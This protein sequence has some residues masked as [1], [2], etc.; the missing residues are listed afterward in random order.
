MVN[1]EL[2][3]L[4][5][6]GS[7]ITVI[8]QKLYND[9]YE[10]FKKSPHLPVTGHII[11]SAINEKTMAIKIQIMCKVKID[12]Y[13]DDIVFIVCPKLNRDVIIGFDIIKYLGLNL[14]VDKNIIFSRRYDI[15]IE[16]EKNETAAECKSFSLRIENIN[17]INIRSLESFDKYDITMDEIEQKVA[18]CDNLSDSKKLNFK[19]NNL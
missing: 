5:D 14:D 18:E 12:K 16:Y 1:L 19:E 13:Y 2:K 10:I 15:N 9:N 3:A 7:E 11:K 8:S 6:S 4:Y 17:E